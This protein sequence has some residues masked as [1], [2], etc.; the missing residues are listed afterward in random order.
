VKRPGAVQAAYMWEI[1]SALRRH[2]IQIPFPQRDVHLRSGFKE[3]TATDEYQP[4]AAKLGV[5]LEKP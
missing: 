3:L 4:G 5:V 1:D 2:N